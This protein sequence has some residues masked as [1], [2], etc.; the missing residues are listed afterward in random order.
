[1]HI[2]DFAYEKYTKEELLEEVKK[3][4]VLQEH[5][6]KLIKKKDRPK[7]YFGINS[8]R[9]EKELEEYIDLVD[10]GEMS[11]DREDDWK[12]SIFERVLMTFYGDDVFE[13]INKKRG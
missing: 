6:Q 7:I 10:K 11:D 13:W 1:M 3:L 8:D 12:Q 2:R 5:L 9:L 4:K